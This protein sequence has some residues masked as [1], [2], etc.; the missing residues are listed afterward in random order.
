MP[1]T[2]RLL[3]R[4]LDR[5]E[6]L[7]A[8]DKPAGAVIAAARTVVR[9]GPIEDTMSGTLIAHP[10][11]PLLAAVPIGAW[12]SALVFDAI[13]ADEAAT[14]QLVG[15]GIL[16]A[17]P[18]ASTGASDWLTTSGAERRVGLVHALVNDAAILLHTAGWLAR[19]T[20]RR[21]RGAAL[22]AAGT[23]L[24]TVGGWLGGH[25]AY[26]LGVG[27]DT[28]AFQKLP[29]DWTDAAALADVGQKPVV[30][31]IDGVPIVLFV[32]PDGVT[33]LADR[34][35]HRGG[36]L[37]EGRV[38]NGCITCPWHGSVFAADGSVESGPA[39]RPQPQLEVRVVQGR[40][41][42]RRQEERA[43]RTNAVGP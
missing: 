25:L 31:Q 29:A 21:G 9:P 2:A 35:S 40:V 10:A 3:D 8:L 20:G 16:A 22:C 6:R 28:T 18:T 42:V 39:T 30:I 11:H 34:C 19:R 37:H 33:A 24:V 17:L 38:D 12:T 43:L 27:V 32:S 1:L 14:R 4:L 13:G 26:G 5:I 36:P 7:D 41:E 15:I 23:A